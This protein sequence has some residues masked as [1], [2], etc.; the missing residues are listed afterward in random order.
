[1]GSRQEALRRSRRQ[2]PARA[3][4]RRPTGG[5]AAARRL[6]TARAGGGRGVQGNEVILRK[7]GMHSLTF[8]NT[9]QTKTSKQG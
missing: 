1:M 4:H 6:W 7:S 9:A 2:G 8:D 3:A 5:R